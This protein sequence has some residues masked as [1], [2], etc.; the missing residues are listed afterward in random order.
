MHGTSRV[1]AP[2]A[3]SGVLCAVVLAVLLLAG[4]GASGCQGWAWEGRTGGG[5]SSSDSSE[6]AGDVE[7]RAAPRRTA[8]VP[9]RGTPPG[10]R[11]ERVSAGPRAACAVGAAPARSAVADVG[12]VV[13]RC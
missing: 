10:G 13:L 3:R 4:G 11:C 5:Q 2:G 8:A 9:P 12:C 7:V 1:P 6:S